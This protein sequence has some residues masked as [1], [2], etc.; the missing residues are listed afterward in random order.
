MKID[1]NCTEAHTIMRY[2][3]NT[4]NG[5]MNETKKKGFAL[6][7]TCALELCGVKFV[8]QKMKRGEIAFNVFS[9]SGGKFPQRQIDDYLESERRVK[10]IIKR[11]E[12]AMKGNI[13]KGEE[14]AA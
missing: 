9:P 11:E 2:F 3:Y 14:V 6:G 10:E 12:D 5:T 7:F 4:M 8:A 1:Y 13:R